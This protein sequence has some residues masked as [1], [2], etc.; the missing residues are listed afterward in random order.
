MTKPGKGLV[1]VYT[2]SG[3][4]KT[5]AALGLAFRAAGHGY[6]THIIQFMKGRIGYG[7]LKAAKMTKGLVKITQGGRASFVSRENPDAEDVR[8][9]KKALALARKEV[10]RGE[11]DILVLDEVNV[12]LDFKLIPL[13]EV[14]DLIKSK[15]NSMEMVLTGRGAPR[16]IVRTA[17]LVTNMREVKHYWQKGVRGRK[18][19]ER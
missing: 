5:T 18:G 13:E 14:L 19:I 17:D 4:G 2:G 3:K 8:L 1:Q 15:P 12:A 7:E 9:A 10:E 16:A 11:V 6:R